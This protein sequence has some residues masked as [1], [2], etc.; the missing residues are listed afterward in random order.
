MTS[1]GDRESDPDERE[2]ASG[3]AEPPDEEWVSLSEFVER[4][5]PR[6]FLEG[7]LGAIGGGA[8][9]VFATGS[10]GATWITVGALAAPIALLLTPV[11]GGIA[12]R[13]LRYGVALAVLVMLIV[14]FTLGREG[15]L[16][17]EL[18]TLGAS[19]L[20]VGAGVHAALLL[21][22]EGRDRGELP[23]GPPWS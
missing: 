19:L 7:V 4:S 11:R 6:I 13:A 2:P 14:S 1:G 10:A 5:L 16:L 15:V 9:S 23:G 17:E 3:D 20:V 8:L 18:L 12:Y 22:V 21:L